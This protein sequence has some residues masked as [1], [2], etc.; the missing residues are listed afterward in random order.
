M[1][2]RTPPEAR[3]NSGLRERSKG[4]DLNHEDGE[5][6]ALHRTTVTSTILVGGS[7]G[8]QQAQKDFTG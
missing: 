1:T 3:L 5:K 4:D 8:M 6:A 2:A 7:L